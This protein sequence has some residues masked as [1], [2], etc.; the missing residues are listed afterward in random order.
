MYNTNSRVTRHHSYT[1]D[2]IHFFTKFVEQVIKFGMA[3]WHH[4]NRNTECSY[5]AMLS[6]N[7]L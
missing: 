2:I 3:T 4:N 7:T 5:A 6:G 1:K